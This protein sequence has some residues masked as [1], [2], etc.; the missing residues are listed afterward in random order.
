MGKPLHSIHADVPILSLV[1]LPKT[2]NILLC[3]AQDGSIA[4]LKI[5]QDFVD[6]TGGWAHWCPVERLAVEDA[7]AG[8]VASGAHD[9]LYIWAVGQGEW[10]RLAALPR[11]TDTLTSK[12]RN[13]IVT[14]IHWM[15]TEQTLL[16]TY[17][18]H[19]VVL[20][21]T[22][23]WSI[24]C[25]FNVNGVIADASLR[26]GDTEIALSNASLGFD[27]Y[28]LKSGSPQ[29][30]LPT[31]VKHRRAIPVLFNHGGN[32]LVG[33]S[34]TGE[35]FVWEINTRRRHQ[36]L[37]LLDHMILTIAAYYDHRRDRFLIATG[38]IGENNDPHVMLWK[39]EETGT[40]TQRSIQYQHHQWMTTLIVTIVKTGDAPEEISVFGFAN[41]MDLWSFIHEFSEG[42]I[43]AERRELEEQQRIEECV[44][45]MLDTIPTVTGAFINGFEPVTEL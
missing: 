20:Y 43:V 8:R 44:K 6:A 39:A 4:S 22:A 13:V 23:S 15:S 14:S 30:F 10:A 45:S 29:Y 35:V 19:G 40:G 26:P 38:A 28:S 34:T 18:F 33:G 42:R 5:G 16:A 9:E 24:I 27:I 11:P 31:E 37:H 1:W 32:T 17:M 12:D 2:G 21:D 41:M 25:A 36:T 3:G 7:H